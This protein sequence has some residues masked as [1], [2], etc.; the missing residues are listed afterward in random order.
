MVS[1]STKNVFL[2][3]RILGESEVSIKI[4]KKENKKNKIK[5]SIQ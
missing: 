5:I 3:Y 1:F 4:N 2:L